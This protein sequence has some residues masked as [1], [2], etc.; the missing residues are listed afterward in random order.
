MRYRRSTVGRSQGT[1]GRSPGRSGRPPDRLTLVQAEVIVDNKDN[2]R[3]DGLFLSF[4][5]SFPTL[6]FFFYFAVGFKKEK[7]RR[8]KKWLKSKLCML[9]ELKL[10]LE[11]I[12]LL[13]LSA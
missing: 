9:C 5:F 2:S 13:N 12:S 11:A 1:L 4:F 10:L 7:G 6:V 3:I 8:K